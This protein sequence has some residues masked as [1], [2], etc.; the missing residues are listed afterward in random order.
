MNELE[1]KLNNLLR[2]LALQ[3]I[4]IN[5]E[6]WYLLAIAAG[7]FLYLAI[8]SELPFLKITFVLFSLVALGFEYAL[9][10]YKEHL[11]EYLKITTPHYHRFFLEVFT[12]LFSITFL[13]VFLLIQRLTVV[14][15]TLVEKI[16]VRNNM[17]RLTDTDIRTID[18]IL[19]K[20][21]KPYKPSRFFKKNYIFLGINEFGKPSYVKL[22]LWQKSH[23]QISGTTGCGKGVFAA[24]LCVQAVRNNESVIV[25]DPKSD[26]FLPHVL[27]DECSQRRIPYVYI[28]LLGSVPQINLFK[29]KAYEQ[30]VELLS[31]GFNLNDTGA[32][33]DFY[34]LFDRKAAGIFA[35]F[36]VANDKPLKQCLLDFCVNHADLLKEAPKF[37]EAINEIAQLNVL[38]ANESS[39][40]KSIEQ[41]AVIYIKG[42]MRNPR[43]LKLQKMVLLS[44]MQ[45]CESRDRSNAKSVLFFLDE[46]KYLISC[47]SLEALGAIRDKKAHVILAHQSIGDLRHSPVGLDPESVISSVNEN[48]SLK[49]VYKVHDPDTAEHFARMSGNIMIDRETRTLNRNAAFAEVT[50]ASRTIRQDQRHYIDTNV[51]HSLPERCGVFFGN[52]LAHMLFTSPIQTTICSE[53]ITPSVFEQPASVANHIYN[54]SKLSLEEELINVDS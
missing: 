29:N 45:Q 40:L 27:A 43:V 39:W 53:N 46:F 36:I 15:N 3:A 9:F 22:A 14:I 44:L 6:Y 28:D 24:M 42:S 30:I 1:L 25:F 8:I 47:E 50:D 10:F 31:A 41:G 51:F 49:F 11:A 20:G 32:E 37:A 13:I 16:L 7:I 54:A 34:K 38:H 19:P 23:V 52:G 35:E 12:G 33:A 17:E 2:E 21:R 4:H 18:K 48:C 5:S 26:E